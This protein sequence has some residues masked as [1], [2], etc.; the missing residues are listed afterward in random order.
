VT[1][2]KDRAALIAAGTAA[3][4]SMS[5][6]ERLCLFSDAIQAEPEGTK[7][8]HGLVEL[9]YHELKSLIA[10]A[11]LAVADSASEARN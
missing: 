6:E 3:I 4:L 1:A 9:F 2:T 5:P 8:W 10:A 7:N 11:E